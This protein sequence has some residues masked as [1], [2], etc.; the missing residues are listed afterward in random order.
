MGLV[1]SAIGFLAVDPRQQGERFTPLAI[2]EF[3]K[4]RAWLKGYGGRRGTGLLQLTVPRQ[5]AADLS[6][7]QAAIEFGVVW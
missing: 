5:K 2:D 6:E 1:T 7:V 3:G 4:A